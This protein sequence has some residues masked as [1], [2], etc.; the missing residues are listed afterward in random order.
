M[1]GATKLVMFTE[2]L[3]AVHFAKVLEAG[4]TPFVRAKFPVLGQHKFQ[5]D[6]DSKHQS[7]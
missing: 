2:N 6:N 7:T 3:T 1:K 4:L 5:Q